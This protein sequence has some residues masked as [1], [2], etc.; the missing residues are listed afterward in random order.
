MKNITNPFA[1]RILGGFCCICLLLWGCKGEKG[2]EPAVVKVSYGMYVDD[3]P[4]YVALEEG[5]WQDEG[6]QVELVRLPGQANNLAAALRGDIACGSINLS[7]AVHAAAKNLPF[8]V[9]AWFGRAH[10]ETHCGIHVDQKSDIRTVRDLKDK[11]IAL[12]GS[13]STKIILNRALEKEGMAQD[14]VKRIEGIK[15]DEAM[16]HEAA[17]RSKGID[18]IIT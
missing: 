13:I 10:E 17:L 3:L 11:R 18:G 7:T 5:F 16:K 12:G 1:G 4:F 15:I 2:K 8:K 14:D 6:I 9:V